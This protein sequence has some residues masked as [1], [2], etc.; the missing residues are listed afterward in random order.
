MR[1]AA[2]L[3]G[4][5]DYERSAA[6]W[7]LLYADGPLGAVDDLRHDRKAQTDARFLGSHK[8][9]KNFFPNRIGDPRT[10]VSETHRKSFLIILY[11]CR[12]FNSQTTATRLQR[13]LR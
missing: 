12:Y 1:R 3:Q 2:L 7:A 8:R 11:C 13:F 9:F 5:E 10:V 4:Q 6:L